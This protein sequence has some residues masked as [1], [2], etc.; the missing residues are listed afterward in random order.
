MTPLPYDTP[1]QDVILR[2]ENRLGQNPNVREKVSAVLK[3]GPKAFRVATLFEIVNP[4]TQEHHHWCLKITSIDRSKTKGWNVK[5]EKTVS[6][7]SDDSQ[8]LHVLSEI[9]KRARAGEFTGQDGEFHL[10]PASDMQSIKSVLRAA[11]GA[12]SQQRMR[13]V[14]AVLE[15]LDVESVSASEWLKVFAAGS[16]GVRRTIA[17]SARLADYRAI[18]NELESLI[19]QGD[20]VSES[21]VQ[22]L[23]TDN[24]WLFGSE[25]SELLSRRSWTR[26]EKLDFMLRR[27]ADDFLEIVEI[28]T[29]LAQPLFRYD[30]S[31]DSYA[32]SRPLAD[33]VGQVIRYVSETERNRDHIIAH[34]GCD[35]LKIRAR[36]IVGRD[37]NSDQRTALREFNAHLHRIEVLTFDQLLR[38]ADRVLSVFED[39][40]TG[41]SPPTA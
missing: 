38:I 33:A 27:T 19:D 23:L 28:K 35:P 25:Y 10:I 9:L 15:N 8:E 29:P 17:I 2:I 21:K 14:S 1:V 37:G 32:P 41:T 34:D 20:E 4:G 22:R 36:I 12:N 39:K 13:V 18:R 26:D 3:N 40:L 7:D 6:L 5:P 11:K 31:H 24:P 16:E 30:P